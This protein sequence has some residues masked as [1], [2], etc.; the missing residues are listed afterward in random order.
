MLTVSPSSGLTA[1]F[2][3]FELLAQRLFYSYS[4]HARNPI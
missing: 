3:R 1:G 2:R 4:R